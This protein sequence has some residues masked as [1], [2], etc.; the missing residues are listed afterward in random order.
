MSGRLS[1]GFLV[2]IAFRKVYDAVRLR[3]NEWFLLHIL[4][5]Q[6]ILGRRYF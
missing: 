5:Q 2:E 4:T 3:K 1:D 6:N